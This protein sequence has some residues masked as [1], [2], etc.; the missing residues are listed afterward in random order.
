MHSDRL[1]CLCDSL[2]FLMIDLAVRYVNRAAFRT[3][4]GCNLRFELPGG[5]DSGMEGF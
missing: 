2:S 4:Y 3:V 5:L 1:R